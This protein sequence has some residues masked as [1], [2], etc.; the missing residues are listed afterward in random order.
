MTNLYKL[1]GI[2]T[3]PSSEQS[4]PVYFHSLKGTKSPILDIFNANLILERGI[5]SVGRSLYEMGL[6]LTTFSY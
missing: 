2:S 3:V 6:L 1:R 5:S 4:T